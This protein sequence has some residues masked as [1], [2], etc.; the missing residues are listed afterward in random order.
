MD[1]SA[2]A[3]TRPEPQSRRID[4]IDAV[5]GVAL[6]GIFVVNIRF[7]S[8]PF[9]CLFDP[10]PRESD[11]LS[12]FL[13]YATKGLFEG[14]FYMLFSML[15]GIGMVLQLNNI[16]RS[17]AH[18]FGRVYVR[19]LLVLAAFGLV[20]ALGLW[21][22][23]ILFIYALFGFILLLMVRRV[24]GRGLILI[25]AACILLGT[26]LF[27]L[28]T[29]LDGAPSTAPDAARPSELVDVQPPADDP[30]S[31][32]SPPPADDNGPLENKSPIERLLASF[33]SESPGP[34]PTNTLWIDAEV[35][36]YRDGPWTQ[37]LLF[38]AISWAMMLVFVVFM[39]FGLTVLGGFSIGAGLMKLDLFSAAQA[40]L[41]RRLTVFG[42]CIAGPLCLAMALLAGRNTDPVTR[43]LSSPVSLWVTPVMAFSGVFLS[44]GYL[45]AISGFAMSAHG[46]ISKK[47]VDLLA[48]AGRMSLTNYLAQT[49]IATAIFYHWGLARF[50]SWSLPSRFLLVL[51][52]Y[53]AQLWMSSMW[54]ARFQFGPAEWL[55]RTLT[56]GR[57]QPFRRVR[58]LRPAM[59][60]GQRPDAQG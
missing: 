24:S 48:S 10:L 6:L 15:F 8:E 58:A 33:S 2:A 53:L 29:Q 34:A 51:V 50:D 7:F 44:L 43:V 19:R 54:L 46:G 31:D 26:L 14:K 35:E 13:H 49:I 38:R 30:L 22:G 32:P 39:G 37:A 5:R 9:P 28:F 16:T 20:H 1:E 56:Y 3:L 11:A 57:C 4:A 55:W 59:A 17:S 25:G 42:L 27:T 47:V 12:S 18:S 21:Y 60:D 40:P 45:S 41:R 52:I 36:A 23:D